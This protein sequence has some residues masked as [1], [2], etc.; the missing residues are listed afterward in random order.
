LIASLERGDIVSGVDPFFHETASG[1][2]IPRHLDE[3]KTSPADGD[4]VSLVAVGRSGDSND[5]RR[6]TLRALLGIFHNALLAI[7][8]FMISLQ[9]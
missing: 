2:K 8:A 4:M 5:V 3:G 7:G 6:L 9:H 1:A